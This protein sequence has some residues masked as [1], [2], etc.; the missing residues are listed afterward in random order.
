[1]GRA[2]HLK[3]DL[4]GTHDMR[5][6]GQCQWAR[7]VALLAGQNFKCPRLDYKMSVRVNGKAPV[8][9]NVRC[10]IKGE[11]AQVRSFPPRSP[12]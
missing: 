5:Q 10:A 4:S 11:D 3:R 1:M 8:K 2:F 9:T 7:H 6:P 12:N